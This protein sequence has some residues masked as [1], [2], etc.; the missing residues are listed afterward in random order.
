MKRFFTSL[1][2]AL[3]AFVRVIAQNP[4]VSTEQSPDRAQLTCVQQTDTS[5]RVFVRY[6]YDGTDYELKNVS[7]TM[8]AEIDGMS[9]KLTDAYGIPIDNEAVRE[10][11]LLEKQGQ[12]LNFILE[13]EKFPVDQLFDLIEDESGDSAWNFRGVRVDTE[14]TKAIDD[15][16]FLASTPSVICGKYYE[17]GISYE[18][19]LRNNV[20]VSAH[21]SYGDDHFT[22]YLTVDNA[23]DHGIL[24]NTRSIKA[25][26]YKQ[27]GNGIKEIEL[28]YISKN[29]YVAEIAM[30]DR[31]V[32]R[33]QVSS[34]AM[35]G[36]STSLSL[37][38]TG[39]PF[40][41]IE[42]AGLR[43]ATGVMADIENA[44][45][46]P[47][48]K[49]LQATREERTKNYLQSESLA[50]GQVLNGLFRIE[51]KKRADNFTITIPMDGYDF[52]FEGYI[53][54]KH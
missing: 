13:F 28:P 20:F 38:A 6:T 45:M 51:R 16:R 5:T 4:V 46:M 17:D 21:H 35:D 27:K 2:F 18:Y 36:V 7:G 24:F 52:V 40:G 50:P 14:S 8:H 53:E 9:Y 11:C 31:Y 22:I 43:V 33:S 23:S 26:C 29:D 12:K 1:L 44:R 19:Y 25:I 48:L 41:S 39:A 34:K 49:E 37:L 10:F 15:E 30:E 3:W 42:R 32:A 54:K 47:Y